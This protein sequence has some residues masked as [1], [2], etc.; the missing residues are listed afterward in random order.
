[1]LNKSNFSV[2][3]AVANQG[4][5][6]GADT[7]SKNGRNLKSHMSKGIYKF[8]AFLTLI[9]M[10]SSCSYRLVDFTVISSKNHGLRFDLANAKR[11]EG[12]S[13]GFL[14]FGTSIKAALDDALEKAGVGYDL[15]IDGVLYKQ[16]NFF[17]VGYKVTGSAVRSS[18]LRAYLGEEGFQNWLARNNVFDPETAI[19]EK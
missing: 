19:V 2:E 14:G 6:M 1:M 15:L 16:D 9:V 5:A 12:K 17:V 18:E 13:M 10:L 3:V 7:I 11:I 4:G 8:F